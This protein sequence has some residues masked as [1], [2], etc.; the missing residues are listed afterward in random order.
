[1][2]EARNL[3]RS[4]SAAVGVLDTHTTV[5]RLKAVGFREEQAEAVVTAIGTATNGNL[6]TRDDLAQLQAAIKEE[7]E[8]FVKTEIQA[9][10]LRLTK[11][12]L[13]T[14]TATTAIVVGLVVAL[15]KLLP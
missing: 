11:L 3:G 13:A 6:A 12:I 14:S 10:E 7:R 1:M 2:L 15:I 5:K 4:W 9:L 8:S